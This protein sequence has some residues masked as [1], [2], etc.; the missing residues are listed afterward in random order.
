M[1]DNKAYSQRSI[2]LLQQLIRFNTTNPPGNEEACILFIKGLLDD[3]GIETALYARTSSRP[4]LYA[5]LKGR[6]SAPPI[7]LQGH[8]DVVTTENQ[9][10]QRPPFEGL[11]EDGTIW[12]R[13]VL[14]MITPNSSYTSRKKQS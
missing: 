10:W 13:G 14:D 4:N 12:G 2:E 11:I 8:V 7:L 6:G 3:I 5:R 1:A 9:N